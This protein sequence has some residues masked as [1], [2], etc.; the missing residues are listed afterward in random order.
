MR[1]CAM[2]NMA[3][4]KGASAGHS[5]ML[6][7]PPSP[8][9]MACLYSGSTSKFLIETKRLHLI[10]QSDLFMCRLCIYEF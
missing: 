6:A 3:S 4:P 8:S 1:T 10:R 5:R 2:I 9:P 7:E